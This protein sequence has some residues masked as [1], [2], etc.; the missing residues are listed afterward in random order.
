MGSRT[1]RG[2]RAAIKID[3]IKGICYIAIDKNG[4]ACEIITDDEYPQKVA[5][6][7]IQEMFREFYNFMAA[8]EMEKISS[9]LTIRLIS[10]HKPEDTAN[11]GDVAELLRPPGGRQDVDAREHS[12]RGDRHHAQDNGGPDE[13]GG[14]SG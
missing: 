1:Q 6:V 9:T 10:G 12:G 7:I 4:L 5:M 13:A 11:A 3:E 2:Q 8:D 14:E